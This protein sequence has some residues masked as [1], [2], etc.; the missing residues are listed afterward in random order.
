MRVASGDLEHQGGAG[1]RGGGRDW[2]AGA[3]SQ[4]T[5][6]FLNVNGLQSKTQALQAWLEGAQHPPDLLGFVET[7]KEEG[8]A[9]TPMADYTRVAVSGSGG[10]RNRGAELYVHKYH[11][12]AEAKYA[13]P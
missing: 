12:R 1:G 13:A 6:A 2:G 9:P 3:F 11:H 7:N 8:E 10:R 5:G 4:V